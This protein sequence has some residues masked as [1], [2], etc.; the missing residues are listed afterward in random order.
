[1]VDAAFSMV[2]LFV[3]LLFVLKQAI[4]DCWCGQVARLFLDCGIR[5]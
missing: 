5:G 3:V 2:A 4:D 1:M